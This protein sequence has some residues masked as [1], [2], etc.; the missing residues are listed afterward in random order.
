MPSGWMYIGLVVALLGALI[1]F[2]G[3]KE[4]D[5]TFVVIGVGVMVIGGIFAL[6]GLPVPSA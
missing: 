2:A 3:R 4:T 6:S 5:K 1:A